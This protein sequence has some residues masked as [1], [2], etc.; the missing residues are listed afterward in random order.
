MTD[1]DELSVSLLTVSL[2]AVWLCNY[3]YYI[4]V[5]GAIQDKRV[6]QSITSGVIQFRLRAELEDT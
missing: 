5:T 3:M 6:H 2:P 4:L 1:G